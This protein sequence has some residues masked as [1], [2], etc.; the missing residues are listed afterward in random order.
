MANSVVRAIKTLDEAD[1]AKLKDRL[2]STLPT[3]SEG[4]IAYGAFANAVKGR[5]R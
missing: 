4:R 1:T 5:V 2:R 3:D